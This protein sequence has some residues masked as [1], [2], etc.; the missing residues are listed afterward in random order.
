MINTAFLMY[1]ELETPGRTLC[2]DGAGYLRYVISDSDFCR[3]LAS[4]KNA[5]FKGVS[6]SAALSTNG[7]GKKVAITFDDG[8]ETDL[9]VAAPLLREFGFN[10]TFYVV[11]GFVGATGYLSKKQLVELAGIGCEIG[12]H[13]MSHRYLS[14]LSDHDLQI[15]IAGAKARLEGI[16]G[17]PVDHFSCPGGRWNRRIALTARE[18][19]YKSVATSRT[20]VNDSTSDSYALSRIAVKRGT[21]LA[22]FDRWCRGEGLMPRKATDSVFAAAKGILGT[23]AYERVRSRILDKPAN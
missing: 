23:A 2:E 8:T 15:E 9:T 12:C 18:S 21:S 19:G 16:I 5:G 11:A 10:A 3:H 20:G 22:D 14:N 7:A 13:S 1:H 6:V 4:I 17:A